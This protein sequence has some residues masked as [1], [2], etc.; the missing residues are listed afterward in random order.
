MFYISK[1]QEQVL[2]IKGSIMSE[3][4]KKFNKLLP[5][6]PEIKMVGAQKENQPTYLNNV[7]QCF[8]P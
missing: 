4:S 2:I 1:Q 7:E 3:L 6:F 8:S 5:S